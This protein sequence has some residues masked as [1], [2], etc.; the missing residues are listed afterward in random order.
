MNQPDVNQLVSQ[1]TDYVNSYSLKPEEFIEAMS[2]EHRT[3]QQSF[4]RLVMKWLEHCASA[5]YR[6]DGRNEATHQISKRLIDAFQESQ[7]YNI[8]PSDYLPLI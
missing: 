6:T 2:C 5:D 3:L 4:T 8:N 7:E 1:I